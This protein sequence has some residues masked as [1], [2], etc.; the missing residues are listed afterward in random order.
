VTRAEVDPGLRA[1]DPAR[2]SRGAP[3]DAGYRDAR[4]LG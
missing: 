4:I 1:F 2:F 3:L